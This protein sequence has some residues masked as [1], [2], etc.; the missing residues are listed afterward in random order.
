MTLLSVAL[1]YYDRQQAELCEENSKT[2]NDPDNN[3]FTELDTMIKKLME[4]VGLRHNVHAK[5]KTKCT[6]WRRYISRP[7][8][9]GAALRSGSRHLVFK[10]NT[11]DKSTVERRY[12]I[13]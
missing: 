7:E 1:E 9:R 13:G 6:K 2:L 5:L 10:M 12:H 4:L 8:T 3:P 11:L